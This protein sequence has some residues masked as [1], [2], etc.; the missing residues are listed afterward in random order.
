MP[1]LIDE[2]VP[3][4]VAVFFRDQG[5]DVMY[6]RKVLAAGTADPVVAA[7][8]NQYSRIIVTWDRDYKKLVQRVGRRF[9]K[10][11]RISFHC[12]ET[13]GAYL[14]EKYIKFIELAYEQAMQETD[15]RM[16]IQVHET[17]IK[18]M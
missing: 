9:R 3:E 17:G 13:R 8:G 10:L 4:S 18:M 12:K 14:A 11:G 15:F 6:V 16:I 2:N 5:H 7:I 1:L